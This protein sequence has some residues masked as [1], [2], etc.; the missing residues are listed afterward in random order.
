MLTAGCASVCAAVGVIVPRYRIYIV[1][2]ALS[3]LRCRICAVVFALSCLV[4]PGAA[5]PPVPRHIKRHVL[6]LISDQYRRLL[7]SHAPSVTLCSFFSHLSSTCRLLPAATTDVHHEHL[8]KSGSG[9]SAGNYDV[10]AMFILSV[11]IL[12][13]LT[14]NW[15]GNSLW[16]AYLAGVW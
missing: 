2:F 13:G 16:P 11:L 14:R 6:R 7:I 15:R 10:V 3:Y 8:A 4:S 9:F 12:C 5:R 1:V